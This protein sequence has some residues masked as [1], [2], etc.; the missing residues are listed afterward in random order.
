MALIDRLCG[1]RPAPA[2]RSPER[3]SERPSPASARA[4]TLDAT[5]VAVGA[6]RPIVSARGGIAGFEF[7]LG[8]ATRRR[9]A[10]RGDPV[11]IRVNVGHLLGAMRLCAQQG[12][13][14]YAE[15]PA[16]WACLSVTPAQ[17]VAGMHLSL[18]PAPDETDAPALA[19]AVAQWRGAQARVGWR[20]G[21]APAAASSLT[22]DFT[23]LPLPGPGA[24]NA[25]AVR[26][27]VR[28]ARAALPAAGLLVTELPDVDTLEAALAAGASLA[29]CHVDGSA[30]PTDART[31]PPQAQRLL[32]LMQQLARDA[33]TDAVVAAVKADVG[34][35]LRL[36]RQMNSAAVAPDVELGSIEQAV[37]LLGRNELYRW[38]CVLLVRLAPARPVSPALQAMAL[39]RARHFELLAADLGE[40]QPGALFTMGLASML[41]LLLR[42]PL[43]DVLASMHLHPLAA[44]ALLE[45]TGPWAAYLGL[46]EVLDEGDLVEA[47]PLVE[48]FGGLAQVMAHS[49][50]AWLFATQAGAGS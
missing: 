1:R 21:A 22:P 17:L 14:A 46:A 29:S 48:P 25:S 40:P 19:R 3:P 7:D 30:A 31:L 26:G 32:A 41:P 5:G 45:R 24:G 9:L 38:V 39:A 28:A 23:V 2:A 42:T 44:Q 11:A 49:A 12:H 37:A 33:D 20:S 15:L 10:E 27:A 34:L 4:P 50:R 16:G 43:D 47:Q 6:R 8:E 36:L 35:S 13:V 18:T